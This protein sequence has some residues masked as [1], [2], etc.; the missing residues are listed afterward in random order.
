MTE[1]PIDV[2]KL[3]RGLIAGLATQPTLV[4][5][6]ESLANLCDKMSLRVVAEGVETAKEEALLRRAGVHYVQGFRFGRPMPL[7]ALQTMFAE[8]TARSRTQSDRTA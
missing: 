1:L 8:L 5:M 3:D 2:V 7:E 6:V 4:H